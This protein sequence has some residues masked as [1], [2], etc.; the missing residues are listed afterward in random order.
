M[1]N[2]TKAP[3]QREMITQSRA[4]SYLDRSAPLAFPPAVRPEIGPSVG[5][6]FR[7]KAARGERARFWLHQTAR[8]PALYR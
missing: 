2:I 7:A 5:E 8:T 6:Y 3:T 4:E 1:G